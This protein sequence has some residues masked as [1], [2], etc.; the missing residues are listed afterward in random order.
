MR[1][2]TSSSKWMRRNSVTFPAFS[3]RSLSAFVRPGR[4][5]RPRGD[6]PRSPIAEGFPFLL[7]GGGFEEF[8]A[9]V[10]EVEL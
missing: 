7:N 9:R 8:E 5:R 4:H 2:Q 10:E 6:E 3:P 1:D